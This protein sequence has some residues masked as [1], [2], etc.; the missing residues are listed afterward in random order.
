[1]KNIK[2]AIL[3]LAAF[4][5]LS[6]V[7]APAQTRPILPELTFKRLLNDLQ[8]TVAST[9]YLGDRI[10][11]TLVLRYGASYDPA[12]KGGMA[13]LVSRMFLK[14]TVEFALKRSDLGGAFRGY[15]KTLKL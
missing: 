10:T 5:A 6:P 8:I 13:R 4:V 1:M 7:L 14:A 15:L 9:P 12:D 3:I 11:I 2:R